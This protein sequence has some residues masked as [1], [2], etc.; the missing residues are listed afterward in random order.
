M[1]ASGRCGDNLSS[2]VHV[3]I[4]GIL[5]L[6]VEDPLIQKGAD[7]RPARG[8]AVALQSHVADVQDRPLFTPSRQAMLGEGG[9]GSPLGSS[10]SFAGPEIGVNFSPPPP[11]ELVSPFHHP[12]GGLSSRE[13]GGQ[14]GWGV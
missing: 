1:P 13:G 8:L 14:D 12:S 4:R 9:A 2:F 10:S 11:G 3:G 5:L 6:D 7:E